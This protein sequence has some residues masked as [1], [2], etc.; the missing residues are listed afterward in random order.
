MF[1]RSHD[2]T[3]TDRLD[4]AMDAQFPLFAFERDDR[5]MYLIETPKRVLHHLEA[6]DIEN[7][8]Y[9]FWDSTG[10]GVRVSVE[11]GAV[12][13]VALCDQTMSLREA[14]ENYAQS[15]GL[16][17]QVG[18]PP[19]DTRRSFQSQLPPRRTLWARLFHK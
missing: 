7:N 3:G 5:S 9:L 19:I 10:S 14:F 11:Q 12:K 4:E 13:H 15:H 17:L 6:I 1:A 8:E 2:N 16:Q 18:K